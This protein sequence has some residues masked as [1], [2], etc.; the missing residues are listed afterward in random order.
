VNGKCANGH[1]QLTE[2]TV[3][4]ETIQ[5]FTMPSMEAVASLLPLKDHASAVTVSL[6]L[7]EVLELTKFLRM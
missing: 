1:W 7:G 6:W 2:C 3:S 4:G 5:T